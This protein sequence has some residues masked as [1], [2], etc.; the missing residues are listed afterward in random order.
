MSGLLSVKLNTPIL[1]EC[2]LR[3]YFLYLIDISKGKKSKTRVTL[4]SKVV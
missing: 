2:A 1:F 4:K 3:N